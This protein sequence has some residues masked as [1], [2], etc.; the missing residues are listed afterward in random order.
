[1]DQNSIWSKRLVGIFIQFVG[2]ELEYEDTITEG[3]GHV[4]P[5]ALTGMV[6]RRPT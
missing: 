2:P 1:M 3:T 5:S 4:G 6:A